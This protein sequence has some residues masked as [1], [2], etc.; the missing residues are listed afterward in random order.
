MARVG[1]SARPT[2]STIQTQP[3]PGAPAARGL[4]LRELWQFP[5]LA[6]AAVMLLAAVVASFLTAPKPEVGGFLTKAA[7]QVESQ[8][9]ADALATLNREVLPRVSAGTLT[10][11]QDRKSVGE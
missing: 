10:P 9:Y 8:D 6:C 2:V 5:V 11:D 1:A 4:R 3:N 7:R